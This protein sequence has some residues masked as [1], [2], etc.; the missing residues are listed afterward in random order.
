MTS[1][2]KVLAFIEETKALCDPKEVVWVDGSE[3]QL[4]AFRKQA[5]EEGILIKLNQELLPGCYLHRT[6]QNDVIL[7]I[8]ADEDSETVHMLYEKTGAIGAG[9]KLGDG[10]VTL[11][12]ERESSAD[13]RGAKKYAEVLGS[14]FAH[15][16]VEFG[17]YGCAGKLK[18]AI[19]LA[20][21]ESGVKAEEIST[22]MTCANGLES[23]AAAE[24]EAL[25]DFASAKKVS[26]KE[27]CG[28][29]RAASSAL[30]LA[31]AALMLSGDIKED[32]GKYV[33]ALGASAGG[34][35]NA[36]VLKKA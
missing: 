26:V 15:C 4:E 29:G 10:A 24:K 27:A 8:G 32:A 11:V 20:L 13:A 14:G 2:K 31:H 9:L 16:P 35:Y 22:V 28:E 17:K 12:L 6:T 7:A 3:S 5:V 1:N 34:S 30:A 18:E 19:K 23:L 21:E 25:A 36:I 33:L